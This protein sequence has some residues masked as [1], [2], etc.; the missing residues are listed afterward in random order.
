MRE[1]RV[2]A[3]QEK[4]Q[5]DWSALAAELEQLAQIR[6]PWQ[7][8]A[9]GWL[10]E[11]ATAWLPTLVASA[12]P[13]G[14]ILDVGSGPGVTACLLAEAFPTSRILAVDI[15]PELLD[16]AADRARGLGLADRVGTLRAD[17]GDSGDHLPAADLIWASSVV[18]HFGDQRAALS[19]LTTALQPGGLLA[20]AE[21]GLPTR[22]LP[23]DTGTGRPGLQARLDAL[24]EDWFAARRDALPGSVA[25]AED[26]PGLLSVAGLTPVASRTFLVDLPAPLDTAT[27]DHVHAMLTRQRDLL[28]DRLDSDD[29]RQLDRLL[30]PDSAHGVLRRPDTFLLAASTVH[31]AARA[32][33]NGNRRTS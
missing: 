27:R 33:V 5:V 23:R 1:R 19:R 30:D 6:S 4:H 17:L 11:L 25:V 16:R 10:H 22:F 18:H 14:L 3:Y 28:D 26:W 31:V 32:P 15:Q 20:V 2:G 7:R 9:A 24:M 21:G 29:R 13:T 8:Q 12:G